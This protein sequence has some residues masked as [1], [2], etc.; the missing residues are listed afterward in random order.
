MSPSVAGTVDSAACAV[1]GARRGSAQGWARLCWGNSS[2]QLDRNDDFPA[3]SQFHNTAISCDMFCLTVLGCAANRM[4]GWEGKELFMMRS[5]LNFSWVRKNVFP[6]S[7]AL[8][9][10]Y[11]ASD[12]LSVLETNNFCYKGPPLYKEKRCKFWLYLTY[13][14]NF[15]NVITELIGWLNWMPAIISLELSKYYH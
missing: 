12:E 3:H 13:R 6:Q 10:L 15:C 4:V 7:D 14:N 1:R 2:R 9:L 5:V 8:V 11:I